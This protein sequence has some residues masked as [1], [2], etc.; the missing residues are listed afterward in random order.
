MPIDSPIRTA[1]CDLLGCDYPIMLAGM[2]GVSRSEL[3]A[4]VVAAG[5]YGLLGM[6]RESP[7]LIRREIA[8]VR[9][10]TDRPF[11]V[12]LIPYGTDPALLEA[13]LLAC[14]EARVH[15]VCFFWEV[16]PDL[17]ARA[18]EA[19]CRVL[20]QV[21]NL[22]DARAAEQAG[23]DIVICQGVEAGGHVHGG[24]ASLALLP[25]VTNALS[26]P[27]LGSGGFASGAGLVAALAL[28]AQGIHCG[29][30]FL[31]TDE[32]FA[33]DFH[34]RRVVEAG[35]DE[36]VYSDVFA[37]NWPPRSPVRTLRNSVTDAYRDDLLGH[38]PDDFPREP[39]AEEEG[40]P[41]YRF[42]TDSPLRSMTGDFEALAPFAGQSCGLVNAVRPAGDVVRRMV[43][44]AE[45]TVAR[46]C[47]RADGRA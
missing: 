35:S 24:V 5:G 4:A 3:V 1:A 15:S 32:S 22:A 34:K 11:G 31:A 2:G 26:I 28:G 44:E 8:A 37:I 14:F 39:V 38:G 18:R 7:D 40:R 47:G 27:V 12:N 43:A 42:S 17:I 30:M 29:T 36:T 45:A 9:A 20:Y 46:L 13:E 25:Q 16:R 19:G 23:A 41:V 21:G 6:V 10:R 33:H